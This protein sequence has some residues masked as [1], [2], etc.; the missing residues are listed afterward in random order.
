MKLKLAISQSTATVAALSLVLAGCG[1]GS[2]SAGSTFTPT[3]T[4]TA[5]ARQ[6][7]TPGQ[8]AL[9]VADVQQVIAQ[10]AGEAKALNYPAIIAVT[11]R[12]GN[13]LAVFRMNGALTRMTISKRTATGE[14][15]PREVDAQGLKVEA[16][17]GAISKAVTAAYLSSSGNAFSTR[18]ASMIVQEHF[19]PA[20]QTPGLE[21]GPLFGVQF[22]QLP[23]SDLNTRYIDGNVGSAAFIGPKRAPLGLS[24][25]AG[26]LPLYKNGVV[27]GAIGVMADGDYAYDPDVT[28]VDG[29]PEEF[30]ALAGIQGFAPADDIRADRIPVDGS[31]LRFADARVE[32]LHPLQTNFAAINNT[33]GTLVPVNGYFDGTAIIPGTAYGTEASGFRYAKSSEFSLAD[34]FVLT[35]GAGNDRYPVK[36]GTDAA[37]VGQ[38]L[39]AVEVRAV[40]EEAF[41]VMTRARAQI[42][43][44]LDSRAQVTISVVDTYGTALGV[45]RGPD[46]PIFGTDVSLQKA[47]TAA[48]FS[49]KVAA[50][51]LQGDLDA[52]VP[53]FVQRVRDF[54][55]DQ[56]AL[57]G[58]IAFADR[59]GG[60]LS[61]PF[62]PDGEVGRPNGPFSRPITDF[63]PFATGLQ[64]ALVKANLIQHA[65]FV[66]GSLKAKDVVQQCTAVPDAPNGKKRLANGI[67]IFPGSVPLYRNGQLVGAIGISGD[68]IDQD[69]MIAFLGANNGGK[70]VGTIG[71]AAKSI[72]ADTIVVNI[73]SGV[74]LRYVNCPFAPFLDTSEQNV[75][76]GL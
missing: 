65:V 24:A 22:S 13:V 16:T 29:D 23:C 8:E 53:A 12:V 30:M 42:R 67:Q 62:F 10:A 11:D 56:T 5:S 48:F 18:T 20:P 47:R 45:V 59:S 63:S 31:T 3:P 69:D 55:G 68:G 27:V 57:T 21:S 35:D 71:N 17:M 51:Q 19:P 37:D 64:I 1:G 40:L 75:C 39:S 2:S 15:S 28:D 33:S 52:E 66:E 58:G 14:I 74:R 36:G 25:D 41:K 34:A 4:P 60:N 43:R 72:R 7:P 46:A 61:R 73:G 44:P 9:T 26:G 49:N 54:L 70:V 6:Y 76:E 38:A 50:A 32:G